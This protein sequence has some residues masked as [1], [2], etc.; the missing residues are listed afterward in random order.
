MKLNQGFRAWSEKFY[1]CHIRVLEHR[2][3]CQYIHL[4]F[5]NDN[6]MDL[7][8]TDCDSISLCPFNG[9]HVSSYSY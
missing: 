6:Y 2:T 1:L 3:A 8:A 4:Q 9:A 5:E 7:Y